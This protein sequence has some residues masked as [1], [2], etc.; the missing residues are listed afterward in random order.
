MILLHA[1]ILCS[2]K[3]KWAIR[4]CGTLGT[5]QQEWR[6]AEGRAHLAALQVSQGGLHQLRQVVTDMPMAHSLQGKSHHLHPRMTPSR[7]NHSMEEKSILRVVH[8]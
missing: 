5:G 7:A 6:K 3:Q 8:P 1:D 4:A 2:S